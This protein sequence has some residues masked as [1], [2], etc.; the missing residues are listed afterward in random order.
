[1]NSQLDYNSLKSTLHKLNTDDTISSA[2]GI[3]C[4]FACVK[5]DLNLDDWLNEILKMEVSYLRHI[6]YWYLRKQDV[7]HCILLLI[8][9]RLKKRSGYYLHTNGGFQC[10]ILPR[11]ELQDE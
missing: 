10:C 5:P 7:E 6:H 1:M 4:G 11:L 2:H 3:L 9:E 8:E